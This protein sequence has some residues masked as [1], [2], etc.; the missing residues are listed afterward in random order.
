MEIRHSSLK[1]R[2][3]ISNQKTNDQKHLWLFRQHSKFGFHQGIADLR[4]FGDYQET[5]YPNQWPMEAKQDVTLKMTLLGDHQ[6]FRE[7]EIYW[8]S[9]SFL[10]IHHPLGKISSL[11]ILA[12]YTAT[13]GE[14]TE[15]WYL[16]IHWSMLRWEK[17]KA[18]NIRA[19]LS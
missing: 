3:Y 2:H 11:V 5:V 4:M 17:I 18:V 16:K 1:H 8:G 12:F 7:K 15:I 6:V 13:K 19:G 9:A 10:R 14:P